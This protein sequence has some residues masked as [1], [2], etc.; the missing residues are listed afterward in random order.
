MGVGGGGDG[1][2][3]R[4]AGLGQRTE[5]GAERVKR[6]GRLFEDE[7]ERCERGEQPVGVQLGQRVHEAA[8][9]QAL[10]GGEA[11]AQAEVQQHGHLPRHGAWRG[12][13]RGVA[14]RVAWRWTWR[15]MARGVACGL[16]VWHGVRIA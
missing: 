7:T 3:A 4:G 9:G 16:C 12:M 13:V 6:L 5:E 1:T 10:G 2:G 15:G 11:L 14:W 8:E